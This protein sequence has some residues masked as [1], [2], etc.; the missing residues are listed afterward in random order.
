M[1]DGTVSGEYRL[2][3]AAD[4][5]PEANDAAEPVVEEP[6][7]TEPA[8]TENTVA[9]NP[10]ADTAAAEET[11]DAEEA[12]DE[13]E[14]GFADGSVIAAEGAW[15]YSSM[16]EALEPI[17]SAVN[18]AAL[19]MQ[20]VDETWA[21]VELTAEDGSVLTGYARLSDLMMY[22]D[23]APE[24]EIPVRSVLIRS[25]LDDAAY[26][27]VGTEVVMTA[28]L[29]GFTETDEYTVQ[30]QYTPDGGTTVF[31]A[32]GGNETSFTYKVNKENFSYTWRIIVTLLPA[33]TPAAE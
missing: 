33:E 17:G 27:T 15:I 29:I 14:E 28:E 7:E 12:G 16:D 30:W 19:R 5:T 26:V 25:T 4:E 6:A 8:E 22:L 11:G 23:E 21:R 24:E 20:L 9:E 32:A 3:A 18:G 10:A 2:T 31:D 1:Q 13:T